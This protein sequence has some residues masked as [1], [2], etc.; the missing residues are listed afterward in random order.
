MIE[1]NVGQRLV[2]AAAQRLA[3]GSGIAHTRP[4]LYLADYQAIDK[5]SCRMLLG[6]AKNFEQPDVKALEQWVTANLKGVKLEHASLVWHPTA[7]AASMVVSWM[8]PSRPL[9][10]AKRMARVAPG[11]YLE[12]ENKVVWEVRESEGQKHLVRLSQENLE[13][14]LAEKKK[15]AGTRSASASFDGLRA[16]GVLHVD[17]GDEV[18][19][20]YKGQT[21]LGRVQAASNGEVSIQCGKERYRVAQDAVMDVVTKDPSTVEDYRQEVSDYYVKNK[22]FPKEYM[23]R[24]M[25]AGQ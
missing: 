2:Q 7:K 1:K 9:S 10:D 25:G 8:L 16:A 23:D 22:I 19:F 13:E 5:G 24:W 20:S 15:R 12:A 6:W 3:G 11:R 17:L 21:L 4:D 14:L 18:K